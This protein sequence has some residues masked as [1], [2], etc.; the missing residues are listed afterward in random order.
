M[1]PVRSNWSCQAAVLC[2]PQRECRTFGKLLRPAALNTGSVSQPTAIHARSMERC[3]VRADEEQQAGESVIVP[4]VCRIA[5]VQSPEPTMNVK[6]LGIIVPALLDSGSGISLIGDTLLEQ[7][8]AKKLKLRNANV[9]LRMAS[10][11]VSNAEACVR[12]RISFNGKTKRQRFVCLPGL[13]VPMLLGRDFLADEGFTLDFPQRGYRLHGQSETTP[14]AE[15]ADSMPV[16][17][18]TEGVAAMYATLPPAVMKSLADFKGTNHQRNQLEAVLTPF[19]GMFT[20]HPGKTDVLVHRINTGDAQ[21]WRC[22][23]RP[24]SQHKRALLDRALDEMID[25]GAVRP[26]ESPWAFPVVLAP[27]KDGTARLCVDYRKLN[28]VTVR[29]SYPLPA[30]SSITYALGNAKFFTTIDCSR[31][32]L[33]IEVHPDDVAKT[34]FTCHRGLFEFVRMPFGLSNSP[35][36]YQRMMDMVLGDAKFNYALWYLDDVT[37]FSRTFEEHLEHLH[38]VLQRMSAAGLTIHPGKLQLATNKI[39]LLGFVVDN[40]VLKPN[41]DKL[42]AIAD[43]PPPRNTKSLQRFLGMIAFYRD[44]IAQCAD[45]SRPLTQLLKKGAKWLWSSEQQTAFDMLLKAITCNA[46]LQLPDLNKQFVLQTDAS[47]YGLGAVLLQE[48]AGA[49]RPVAFASHTLTGAERNYSVTEKECLA[50][51]FALKKFDMFLDGTEFVIQ[52]DHQ[53]LSWLK[54]LPNPSGRLARWALTLQRY[55]YVIEYKKGSTNTVA[56]ALSRA[57]LSI[58]TQVE[59]E[60]VCGH[61]TT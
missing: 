6:A 46:S 23:P 22:N 54:R 43:F 41:P 26:S 15:K 5:Q 45:I 10:N 31:G 57:P 51:I 17:E 60:T 19:S 33:Q 16:P 49:L 14:F 8:N 7:C 37:V 18:N 36:S 38:T 61:D 25:T 34:A 52:T 56:D 47:D 24:L 27:K 9:Q 12:L 13:S 50:I 58:E 53:A 35:S 32:Y 2:A 55:D 11:H 42:R 39:N 30:I 29:D 3:P 21:P 20:E 59:P 1:L 44:F 4:S 28:A 40:G 48:C